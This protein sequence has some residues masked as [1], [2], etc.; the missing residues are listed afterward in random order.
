[1]LQKDVKVSTEI[2]SHLHPN[3]FNYV[4]CATKKISSVYNAD[5]TEKVSLF[6]KTMFSKYVQILHW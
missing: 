5:K 2:V 3:D 6:R 1:M 4:M